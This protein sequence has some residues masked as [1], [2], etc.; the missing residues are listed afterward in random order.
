[1]VR[2]VRSRQ[3]GR[4][5]LAR[6]AWND[7]LRE[8]ALPDA[9]RI[10]EAGQRRSFAI[11]RLEDGEQAGDDE[12]IVQPSRDRRHSWGARTRTSTNRARTCRAAITPRPTALPAHSIKAPSTNHDAA[13]CEVDLPCGAGLRWVDDHHRTTWEGR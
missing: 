9:L 7:T 11:E 12:K 4:L 3:Q 5:N 2:R 10:P 1:M 13:T 8:V 6:I